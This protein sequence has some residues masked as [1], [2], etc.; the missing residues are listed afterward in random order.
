MSDVQTAKTK[1]QAAVMDMKLKQAKG[2]Q[3]LQANAVAHRQ[4]MEQKQQE[5]LFSMVER[6]QKAKETKQEKKDA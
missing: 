2:Q 3:D 5:S 4:N 6:M 1:Q